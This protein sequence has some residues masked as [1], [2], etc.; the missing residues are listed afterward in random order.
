MEMM[1]GEN[2]WTESIRNQVKRLSSL[3]NQITMLARMEEAQK[4]RSW[5][6]WIFLLC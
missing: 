3:T 5:K 2:E 1:Q 4:N 6:R